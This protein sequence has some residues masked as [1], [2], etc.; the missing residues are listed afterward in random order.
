MMKMIRKG[1]PASIVQCPQLEM[2]STKRNHK[3]SLEV[4]GLVQEHKKVFQDPPMKMPLNREIKHPIELKTGSGP[5][6]IKSF[7]S[8][9]HQ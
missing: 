7:R 6:N 4:Q 9:H 3:E 2:L 8:P 5:L 1:A